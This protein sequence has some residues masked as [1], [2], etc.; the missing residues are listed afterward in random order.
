MGNVTTSEKRSNSSLKHSNNNAGRKASAA[1]GSDKSTNEITKLQ[2]TVGNRAV[3]EMM[4][5]SMNSNMSS[6]T[7]MRLPQNVMSKMEQSFGTNFSNVKI[8]ED[9]KALSM[10]AR[11]YTQ[12]N[13][14][15]FAPGQFL[16]QTQRGQSLIGHELSHVVQQREGRVSKSSGGSPINMDRHLESSADKAGERAASGRHA[17]TGRTSAISSNSTSS[18]VQMKSI[19]SN[20]APIQASFFGSIG[21]FA[22]KAFSGIKSFGGKALNFGMKAG[23]SFVANGGLQ[24]LA[25]MYL[26]KKAGGGAMQGFMAN[27]GMDVASGMLGGPNNSTG[28]GQAA[29]GQAAGG[30]AAGGQQAGGGDPLVGLAGL[31]GTLLGGGQKGNEAVV[32]QGGAGSDSHLAKKPVLE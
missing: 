22:K 31:L 11:A 3:S 12:G 20:N 24:L 5:G 10:G 29:G 17:D 25:G 23:K 6:P 26:N 18:A 2:S 8:H 9:P 32:E 27:G 16:P 1:K 7:E 28:G 21:G 14:I 30:Q 15:F 4:K 13:N 19:D